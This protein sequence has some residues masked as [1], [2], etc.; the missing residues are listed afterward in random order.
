ML[1]KRSLC[2]AAGIW[3]ER[4]KASLSMMPRAKK[5]AAESGS[6]EFNREASNWMTGAIRDESGKSEQS[7]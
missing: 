2:D 6:E 4:M 1:C 5:R 3:R 7:C